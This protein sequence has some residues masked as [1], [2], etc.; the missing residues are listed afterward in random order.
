MFSLPKWL[1]F[2]KP[3]FIALQC[4]KIN[5]RCFKV[6]TVKAEE[7]YSDFSH[8]GPQFGNLIDVLCARVHQV[9]LIIV[10]NASVGGFCVIG[11]IFLKAKW[12]R[13]C[14]VLRVLWHTAGGSPPIK[15]IQPYVFVQS[16]SV[17]WQ[18]TAA[19]VQE[20]Y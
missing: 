12:A 3:N 19:S 4:V 20:P 17:W 9:K 18:L 5:L 8:N 15:W 7:S 13:Y 16:D 10:Q 14:G 1:S 2:L 11:E 6:Q